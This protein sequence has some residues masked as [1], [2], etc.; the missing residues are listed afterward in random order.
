MTVSVAS[1]TQGV[2]AGPTRRAGGL[3]PYHIVAGVVVLLF[4]WIPGVSSSFVIDADYACEFAIVAFSLVLLT[5]WVGQISLGQAAFVGVGAFTSANVARHLGMAFPLDLPVACIAGAA[6]ATVLGLVALR[7]RGLYLAVATLIFAYMCDSYLFSASW[8]V[9]SGGSVSIRN[10]PI[11]RPDTLT[12]FDISDP[13]IFY[14]VVIA[15]LVACWF[16]LANLRDSK[17][18]R[19]FFAVRGSELAAASL[20]IDVTRYKLLAFAVSG[21]IAGLAGNLIMT[22]RLSASP[23]LFSFTQSFFF[24]SLAVV[25]GITGLGGAVAAALV[26]AVLNDEVALPFLNGWIDLVSTGLLLVVLLVYPGGLGALGR[27]GRE[28]M[29][30]AGHVLARFLDEQEQRARVAATSRALGDD[31][32]NAGRYLRVMARLR[33][34]RSPVTRRSIDL[35][36]ALGGDTGDAGDALQPLTR[37]VGPP[38][39]AQPNAIEPDLVPRRRPSVVASPPSSGD[40]AEQ[41]AVLEAEGIVVRFGG[42]LAVD[43]VSLAVHEREIVGLIG[44]NGAGKTTAFNAIAGLN[45]PAAGRVRLFGQDV[46]D[47]SVVARAQSGVGRTFQLLQVFPQLTVFDNVLIG[48]HVLNPTGALSHLLVT[49]RAIHA[50]AEAC[51]RVRLAIELLG[52]E[53]YAERPA[54]GLPFGILRL[55]EIARAIVTGAPLLML[56]EPASGLDNSE[57]EDL[58]ALLRELRARLGLSILII[59]HDVRMVVSLCDHI[60]VLNQGRLL[61]HGTPAEVSRHPEVVAAYLGRRPQAREAALPVSG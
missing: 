12:Y 36:A 61:A 1:L 22:N 38:R 56:D 44:P 18:G 58:A 4:P 11:G 19:A 25:G 42:L 6:V 40:R 16:A 10:R 27:A 46:T 3:R 45:Q 34:P 50:E 17:T 31:D 35:V 9:G 39:A 21:T 43:D 26:F 59:E 7:V 5:G 47:L 24:L 53:A 60:Y 14:L 13:K 33:R 28:R 37:A 15:A 52:L 41:P 49:G 55:I 54:G 57:T 32:R 29:L 51:D 23:S 30:R 20:G 2:A 8:F 48:T